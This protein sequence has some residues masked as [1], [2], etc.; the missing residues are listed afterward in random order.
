MTKWYIY[1]TT[2]F[3]TESSGNYTSHIISTIYQSCEMKQ[4]LQT[5][6]VSSTKRQ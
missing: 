4:Q 1:S 2:I 5:R 6:D 3:F